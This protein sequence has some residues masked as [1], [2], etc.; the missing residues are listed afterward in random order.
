MEARG[1]EHLRLVAQQGQ[2]RC[3][4]A[5]VGEHDREIDRDPAGAVPGATW[6]QSTQ[7][8]R[9]GSGQTSGVG[10]VGQQ[11]GSRV[12]DHPVT[13]GREDELGTRPGRVRA[14]SALRL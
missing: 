1:A 3:R 11:A 9:A 2:V 7:R 14:E 10:E 12:A 8:V 6:S 5:A 4:L 13:V